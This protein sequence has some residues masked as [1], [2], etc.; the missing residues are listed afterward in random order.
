MKYDPVFPVLQAAYSA[1]L[2]R[3]AGCEQRYL[4]QL[5]NTLFNSHKPALW[6]FSVMM[7]HY[8]RGDLLF[9]RGDQKAWSDKVREYHQ[10]GSMGIQLTNPPIATSRCWSSCSRRPSRRCGRIRRRM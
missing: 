4:I 7:E 8:D 6:V 10:P 1:K 5:A 2:R 9:E 3:P